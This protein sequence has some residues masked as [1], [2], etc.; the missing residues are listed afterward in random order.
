MRKLFLVAV[1]FLS[2]VTLAQ[3]QRG[4]GQRPSQTGGGQ[5]Q[6]FDPEQM[7]QR[8][9][10]RLNEAVTLTDAQKVKVKEIL[11]KGSDKQR[12]MFQSM[13]A[14][15]T[16]PSEADRDKMRTQRDELRKKQD[17]EI[18]A[19]LTSEQLP[20]Y[21][22]YLKEREARMKERMNNGGGGPR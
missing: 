4:G 16:Q 11:K 13:R 21:E 7:M 9:I 12:E 6:Q 10:D 14:S 15:G 1:M 22:A 3:A 5:R 19:V 2:V 20:K 17:A 8:Q 18:K